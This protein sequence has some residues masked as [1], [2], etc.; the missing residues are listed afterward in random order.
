MSSTLTCRLAVRRRPSGDRLSVVAAAWSLIL[1]S[2][3]PFTPPF[4]VCSLSTLLAPQVVL[5]APAGSSSTTGI[6]TA[7]AA[8]SWG[9]PSFIT[10]EQLNDGVAVQVEK[11]VTLTEGPHEL[12]VVATVDRAEV[13]PMLTALRL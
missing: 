4:S 5:V 8:P 7:P 11:L 12:V 13:R 3:L 10:E 9:A 6:T 2:A 1:L